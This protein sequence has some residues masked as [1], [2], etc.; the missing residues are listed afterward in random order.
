MA[1][2]SVISLRSIFLAA[3]VGSIVVSAQAAE[4]PQPGSTRSTVTAV[5][6]A[7]LRKA[8]VAQGGGVEL[9]AST[10]SDTELAAMRP[11]YEKLKPRM[12][13]NAE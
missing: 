5:Q 1:I 2:P 3:C 7:P 4:V 10:L 11:D 8:R 12:R 13:S 6:K 9:V